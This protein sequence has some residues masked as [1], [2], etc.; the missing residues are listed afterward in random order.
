MAGHIFYKWS[1]YSKS[2][3]SFSL[4]VHQLRVLCQHS[5]LMNEKSWHI[6]TIHIK[7]LT[8]FSIYNNNYCKIWSSLSTDPLFCLELIE[9]TSLT[10]HLTPPVVWDRNEPKREG[11][12]RGKIEGCFKKSFF[13][14]HSQMLQMACS[15]K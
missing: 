6:M 13:C 12:G 5:Y 14:S 11:V 15:K 1:F 4:A 7:A 2:F 9:I 8:L 3:L 10:K